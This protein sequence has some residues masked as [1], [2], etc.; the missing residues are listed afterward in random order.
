[1]VQMPITEYEVISI[2]HQLYHKILT[3][4]HTA[5]AY[6]FFG[7]TIMIRFKLQ[8]NIQKCRF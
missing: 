7:S 8:K 3:A 1:M 6:N 5:T 4:I 2:L